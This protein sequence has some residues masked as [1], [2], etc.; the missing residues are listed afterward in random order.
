MTTQGV[1]HFVARMLPE[2]YALSL[3]SRLPEQMRKVRTTAPYRGAKIFLYTGESVG[4]RI[5]YL[6]DFEGEQIDIFLSLLAPGMTLFD[7]GANIGVYTLTAAVRGIKTYAFEPDP[8]IIRDFLQPGIA[9]NHGID[10]VIVP[11]AVS[12]HKGKISFYSHRPGNFG[13]GSTVSGEESR[14]IDVPS[15]TLDSYVERYGIPDIVKMDIEGAEWHAVAGAPRTL[16]RPDAP[17][18]FIEIHPPSIKELG[19]TV[20]KLVK[21]FHDAG[22]RMFGIKKFLDGPV[23][24][25]D[26]VVFTKNALFHPHL[27]E[28]RG[29]RIS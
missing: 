26:W 15:D 19:G 10:A 8:E 16:A 7:V 3:A 18:F 9:E 17:M 14:R 4:R 21:K 6:N 29:L 22:Y 11:E 13:V 2:R 28:L 12:Q 27:V 20:E 5:N 24:N 23:G 25:H 1:I